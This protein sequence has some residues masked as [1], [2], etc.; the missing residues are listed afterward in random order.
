[1]AYQITN[2]ASNDTYETMLIIHN[3]NR[4]AT[5]I[6]L[7]KNGGWVMVINGEET[8]L[9]PI[10]TYKGGQSLRL[11]ANS[12]FVF[13]QDPSIGDYSPLPIILLST[14]GSIALLGGVWFFFIKKK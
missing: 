7:P 13:Y 8:S 4:K 11:S 9:E 12:T 3:A 5:R 1:L 2:D 14:F 10:H 6:T